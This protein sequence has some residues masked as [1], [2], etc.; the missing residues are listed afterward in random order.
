MRMVLLIPIAGVLLAIMVISISLFSYN[1]FTLEKEETDGHFIPE[2]NN[3]YMEY[4][5]ERLQT[6]LSTNKLESLAVITLAVRIKTQTLLDANNIARIRFLW[7]SILSDDSLL[8][9]RSHPSSFLIKTDK[10]VLVITTLTL[11]E[12]TISRIDG[13]IEIITYDGAVISRNVFWVGEIELR[14]DSPVYIEIVS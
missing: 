12:S 4:R 6:G 5:E 3:T 2:F 14:G 13:E 8:L 7:V 9:N 10:E 11:E 1:Y